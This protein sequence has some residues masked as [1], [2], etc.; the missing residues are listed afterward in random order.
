MEIPLWEARNHLVNREILEEYEKSPNCVQVQL[1]EAPN[2]LIIL[3][4]L[5][6][7]R[8]QVARRKINLNWLK[9]RWM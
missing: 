3:D 9:S 8:N 5:A 1:R 7:L 6:E 4:Y 2:Q